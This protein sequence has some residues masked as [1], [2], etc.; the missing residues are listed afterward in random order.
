M[1]SILFLAFSLV[2]A[3]TL[4]AIV[5]IDYRSERKE[6]VRLLAGAGEETRTN[7]TIALRQARYL[8][9]A[10]VSFHF[11]AVCFV[12]T[13]PAENLKLSQG[14]PDS[15]YLV[16][17]LLLLGFGSVIFGIINLLNKLGQASPE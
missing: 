9:N 16:A 6:I 12:L 2:G 3:T 11:S 5:S 4:V 8:R 10:L 1:N 14:W 7:M 15:L 13:V 17:V